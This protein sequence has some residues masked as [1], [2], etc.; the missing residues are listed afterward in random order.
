MDL[1]NAAYF[2]TLAQIGI[3]FAGFATILMALRETRGRPMSKFDLWVAK[4]YI[5]SGLVTAA[6][7]MLAPLL[8]SFGLGERMT[9]QIASLLVGIPALAM[10]LLAPGQWRARTDMPVRPRLWVQIGIG[11][12]VNGALLFNAAGW[13]LPPSGN[14]LMLA[15]SWNLFGFF[16][17]FAE[18]VNFFFED[19]NG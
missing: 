12:I 9:W 18:S 17:Q 2:Y 6:N 1:P 3:A 15:I 7:A 11:L 8:F 16:A 13:P 5:Q 10:L 14:F 4:S 19:S